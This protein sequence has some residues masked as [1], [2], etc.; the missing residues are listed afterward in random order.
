MMMMSK[1]AIFLVVFSSAISYYCS[2][3]QPRFPAPV[4]QRGLHSRGTLGY[5]DFSKIFGPQEATERQIRE[6]AAEY[7]PRPKQEHN[8]TKDEKTRDEI[9]SSAK[10]DATTNSTMPKR[11]APGR[12]N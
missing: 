9:L 5:D 12:R 2:A 6:L 4:V 11:N 7:R 1:W 8:R 10:S 3:F